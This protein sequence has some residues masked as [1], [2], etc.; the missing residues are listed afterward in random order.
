VDI[1]NKEIESVGIFTKSKRRLRDESA[2]DLETKKQ[3]HVKAIDRYNTERDKLAEMKRKRLDDRKAAMAKVVAAGGTAEDIV[4]DSE[5]LRAIAKQ[6]LFCQALFRAAEDARL[7]VSAAEDALELAEREAER[8]AREETLTQLARHLEAAK[9]LDDALVARYGRGFGISSLIGEIR[10]AAEEC[11]QFEENLR[12]G[13]W[14][15]TGTSFN[16]QSSPPQVALQRVAKGD[17][18]EFCDPRDARRHAAQVDALRA[19]IAA[20]I[21][22]HD[23][24]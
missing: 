3:R 16:E 5:L 9:P 18:W 23:E 14:N 2:Q 24:A 17:G 6:K 8:A 19:E 20:A 21:E 12:I 1:E 10:A 11:A 15:P 4:D 7:A 13:R 22:K